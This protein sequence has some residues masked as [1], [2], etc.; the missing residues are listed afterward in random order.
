MPYNVGMN[1]NT[2]GVY[3]IRHR[4]SGKVYVGSST[5]VRARLNQHRHHLRHGTHLNARL[6]A[7]WAADGEQA[8][9]FTVLESTDTSADLLALEQKWLD[10]LQAAD[11]E[12]GYNIDPHAGDPLG[13]RMTPEQRQQMAERSQGN[14]Y[15]VGHHYRGR[16]TEADIPHIFTRMAAGV[17]LRDVAAEFH[18]STKNTISVVRRETWWQVDIPADVVNRAQANIPSRVKLTADQVREIRQRLAAGETQA[19]LC[20]VYGVSKGTM[21]MISTGAIWRDALP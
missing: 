15:G 18:I 17:P 14:R 19:A 13:R 2:I 11:P 9:E 6:Q 10:Q 5:N 4:A 7:A 20:A 12:H 8:F 3:A 21:S 1:S 16:L